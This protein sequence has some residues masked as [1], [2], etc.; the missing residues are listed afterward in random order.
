MSAPFDQRSAR[1]WN[2][3]NS[4]EDFWRIS[5]WPAY[6]RE[7]CLKPHKAYRER[8]RLFLFFVANGV[9]PVL[10]YYWVCIRDIDYGRP[11]YE[12][13]DASANAQMNAMIADAR[14]G[15]IYSKAK[16][17]DMHLGRVAAGPEAE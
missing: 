6:V 8:Y 5:A 2:F 7:M 13:Y 4:G 15:K 12:S 17:F 11:V 10:A 16:W 14:S 3:F 9:E 1:V